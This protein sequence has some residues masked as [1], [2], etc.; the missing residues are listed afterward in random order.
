[1]RRHALHNRLGSV[2]LVVFCGLYFLGDSGS[3][4][5]TTNMESAFT[6]SSVVGFGAALVFSLWPYDGWNNANYVVEELKDT[7]QLPQVITIGVSFVVIVY[8]IMNFMYAT[9]AIVP[10]QSGAFLAHPPSVL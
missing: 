8:L 10:H 1:M 4:V 2:V 6:G 3:H 7:K 9:G 5:L